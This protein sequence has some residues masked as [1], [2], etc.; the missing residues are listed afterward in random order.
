MKPPLGLLLGVAFLVGCIPFDQTEQSVGVQLTPWH[1]ATAISTVPAATPEALDTTPIPAPTPTPT[2]HIVTLGETISSIALRY[3]LDMNTLLAANPEID[4]YSLIVGDQVIIPAGN[5]Q[6][7]IGGLTE[8]LALDVSQPECSRTPEG[9]LWCFAVLSNPLDEAASNLA[10]T[11]KALN[12]SSE[13]IASH[14]APA[15]LN[16][17]DPGETLPASVYFASPLPATLNVTASLASAFPAS[18][19]GKTFFPVD[20]GSPLIEISGRL[21]KVSGEAVTAAD[22]GKT[23]DVWVAALAYDINGNLVG[24]RRAENRVTLAEG[25]G[26]NFDLYVYSTGGVINSVI[27]KAEAILVN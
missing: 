1:T 10:V 6:V 5:E 14:T 23:V 20:T 16:K 11:F 26:L 21:A 25:K 18:Q 27:I 19:S 8:P 24:M 7:Q 12:A 2:I 15:I 22:P 4:P 17:L 3:G 9:G 13:E